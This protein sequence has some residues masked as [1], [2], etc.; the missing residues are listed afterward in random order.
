MLCSATASGRSVV[1][2][3]DIKYLKQILGNKV[4]NLLIDE[5]HTFDKLVSRT[6]PSGHK[7]EIVPL[8]KFQYPKIDPNRYEIPEKY[9][10]MFSKEA[11]EEGLVEK[12]FRIT[13][14]D[15]SRDL[16]P[17]Q[18]AKDVSFKLYRLFQFIEAY[19]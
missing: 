2:N 3:Y 19:H 7:V 4:H 18:S 1:S 13:I 8:E 10:K 9:K 16:Q 17:D 11:Q 6:Y 15:L 14:R 12:W 5:K